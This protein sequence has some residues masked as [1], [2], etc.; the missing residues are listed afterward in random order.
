[1]TTIRYNSAAIRKLRQSLPRGSRRIIQKKSARADR[2][3]G[4]SMQYI[5]DV[6]N[7]KKYNQ[8]ILDIAFEYAK[9]L[10]NLINENSSRI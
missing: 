1:M 8:E 3:K 5:W 10:R 9:A 2:P 4:Y 6:L 7:E